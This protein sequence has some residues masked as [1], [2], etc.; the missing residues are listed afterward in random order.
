MV[1]TEGVPVVDFVPPNN[2]IRFRYRVFHNYCS[3]VDSRILLNN[4]FFFHARNERFV[5]SYLAFFLW[6]KIDIIIKY[7][8]KNSH[9]S[10]FFSKDL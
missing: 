9:I 7:L 10:I 3:V 5:C 4:I 2:K 8:Q 6:V 1:V